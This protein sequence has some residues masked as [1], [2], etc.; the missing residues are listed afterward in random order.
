MAKP[1][2]NLNGFQFG[3]WLVIGTKP[4]KRKWLCRC[5]C[6]KEKYVY[7]HSLLNG[8]STSCGCLGK[9]SRIVDLTG[10]RFGRLEAMKII[11]KKPTMWECRCDC[12]NVVVVSATNLK[13]GKAKS[14]GCIN[15]ERMRSLSYEGTNPL[16]VLSPKLSKRNTTGV[17]GV[18][19]EGKKYIMEIMF[20]GKRIRERY[21]TLEEAANR[22]KELERELYSNIIKK[23]PASK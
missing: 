17:K 15:A 8:D 6:G 21:D 12:G 19:R 1:A 2:T 14:C 22:R 16:S 3:N 7:G 20:K 18:S 13:A 4:I 11:S 5:T 23:A 10:Q 9:P